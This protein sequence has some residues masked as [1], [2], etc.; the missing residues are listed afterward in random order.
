VIGSRDAWL[1]SSLIACPGLYLPKAAQVQPK[2]AGEL[3][4][5]PPVKFRENVVGEGHGRWIFVNHLA[6]FN[7]ENEFNKKMV[8]MPRKY[9]TSE[10]LQTKF[11][12]QTNTLDQNR[13]F[14]ML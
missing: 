4:Q 12:F 1:S 8:V 11:H 7:V 6:V 10:Y 2:P 9:D 13:Y 3:D 14:A 5:P